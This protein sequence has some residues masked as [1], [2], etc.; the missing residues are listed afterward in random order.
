MSL[1]NADQFREIQHN[2]GKRTE[3]KLQNLLR[4]N[5]EN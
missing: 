4:I 3:T 1:I 5:L 2:P